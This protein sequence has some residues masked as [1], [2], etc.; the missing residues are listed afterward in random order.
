MTSASDLAAA[1]TSLQRE[2]TPAASPPM[3]RRMLEEQRQFRTEQLTELADELAVLTAVV[4][5]SESGAAAVGTAHIQVLDVLVQGARS[6]LADIDV[7]LSRM[8]D[9]TYGLCAACGEPIALARLEILPHCRL[10][11]ACQQLDETRAGRD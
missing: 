3:L 9:G 11:L 8:E 2:D 6:S 10:C 1:T 5:R 4:A 7:A